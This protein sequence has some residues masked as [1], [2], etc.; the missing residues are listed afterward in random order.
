M[1]FLGLF[2]LKKMASYY[3]CVTTGLDPKA[4]RGSGGEGGGGD[5]NPEGFKLRSF[6]SPCLVQ[7]CYVGVSTLPSRDV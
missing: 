2:S 1:I 6:G 5:N 7:F 4:P 3:F